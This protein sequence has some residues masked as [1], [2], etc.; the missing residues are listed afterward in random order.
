MIDSK[1]N[2]GE[3]RIQLIMKINFS[4]SRNFFVTRDMHSKSD[5]IEIMMGSNTNEITENLFNSLLRRYQGG[6]SESM[7]GNEF[8]L[9]YVKS[10][11]YVLH[12]IDLKRSGSYIETPKWLKNKKATI[13]CRNRKCFQYR[14]EK[15]M[16]SICNYNCIEL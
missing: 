12:N 1:K 11:N 16:L 7:I 9:I 4:S 5:N 13:N 8:V 14:N 2:S 10:L 6:L 15:E 3:W